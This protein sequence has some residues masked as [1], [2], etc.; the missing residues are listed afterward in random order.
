MNGLKEKA[1]EKMLDEMNKK[2]SDIEDSIHNWLCDQTDDE[3]FQGILKDGRTIKGAVQYCIS[4][5]SKI[6]MG[7][8]AMVS[9]DTAFRWVY[10]YFTDEKAPKNLNMV[11]ATVTTSAPP[12]TTKGKRK[13]AEPQLIE[14]EQLDLLN[15]L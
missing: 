13:K 8:G 14:G 7:N 1:L 2:H 6:K 15:F 4:Q 5:A 12:K 9:D 10:T 11:K 3:L